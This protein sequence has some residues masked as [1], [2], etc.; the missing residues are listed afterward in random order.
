MILWTSNGTVHAGDGYGDSYT[1][2]VENAKKYDD[3]IISSK[4]ST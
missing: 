1:Y 3:Q 4:I 2:L